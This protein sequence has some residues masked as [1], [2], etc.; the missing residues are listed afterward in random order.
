MSSSASFLQDRNSS[1]NA[2]KV[3]DEFIVSP[4]WLIKDNATDFNCTP[5]DELRNQS[6]LPEDYECGAYEVSAGA[7][8]VIWSF[9]AIALL[10]SAIHLL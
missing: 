8:P 1:K 9:A 6:V 3:L 10:M 4:L 2:S 5:F 7:T